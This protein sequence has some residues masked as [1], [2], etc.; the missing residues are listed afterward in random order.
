VAITNPRDIP[1]LLLWLSADSLSL[2]AGAN[3]NTWNDL[4]GANNHCTF[5]NISDSGL[6]KY[7]P[8]GGPA[9]GPQVVL[10]G[11]GVSE[12]MNLPAAIFSGVTAAEAFVGIKS[13]NQNA[14]LWSVS[15]GGGLAS[16]YPH[17]SGYYENFGL[18]G[19]RPQITST[20]AWATS[21]QQINTRA[22]AGNFV[23]SAASG[24]FTTYS[25]SGKTIG[26]DVTPRML[27][28]NI[29]GMSGGISVVLLWNK[30]LNTTERADVNTWL[31]ANPSG[32][33]PGTPPNVPTGLN[34]TAITKSG[35][36][37]DWTAPASGPTPTG[38]DVR[39]NGAAEGT[40]GWADIGVATEHEL[41][42]L[43]ANT[44]Y[45][46]EV[47]SVGA[48][49]NS[50]WVS[51]LFTT[52]GA[53]FVKWWDGDSMEPAQLLGWWNGTAIQP[54]EVLGWWD[55]DSIEPIEWVATLGGYPAEV[56]AD[57]PLAYYRL[58]EASGTAMLDSSGSGRHGTYTAVTLG[59]AGLLG[60]DADKAAT[61]NG[62]TSEGIVPYAAWMSPSAVT[63]EAII[64]PGVDTGTHLI[65]GRTNLGSLS[66]ANYQVYLYQDATRLCAHVR[67]GGVASDLQGAL[68][69]VQVGVR[70]HVA[71]TYNG[72]NAV[73]YINGVATSTITKTG[74]LAS[75][76]TLP[77]VV[78]ASSWN[79]LRYPG[80]LDE[81]AFYGTGLSAARIAAHYAARGVLTYAAVVLAD[82]PSAYY[83]LGDPEPTFTHYGYA[84][85]SR[86]SISE[87]SQYA[88]VDVSPTTYWTT[89]GVPTGWLLIQFTA[90][91][92]IT[93]YSIQRRD[94]L[95]N[96]NPKD[97][98]MEGSD[99]GTTWTVIDTRT[100]I[101][102]PT[103]GEIKSFT[104]TAVSPGYTYYRLN[105]TANNGDTY[106][107]VASLLMGDIL[108]RD[109][110]G[111]GRHGTYNL[112]TRGAAG[113]LTGD[114]DTAATFNGTTSYGHVV[115]YAAWMDPANF[116][117]EARIKTSGTG[118]RAI[119]D[120]DGTTRSWQLR[121]NGGN[122]EFVKIAGGIV[123]IT[124]TAT[125][126]NGAW[127]H[128]AVT[129]DGTNLV[130]YIDG[131][132]V[133]TTAMSSPAGAATPIRIGC[134]W[135]GSPAAVWNG[136]IDEAA[137][138][139]T[140]LSAAQIAA[141]VAAL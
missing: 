6:F 28:S 125:L 128:V 84:H 43:A 25:A 53:P 7:Q 46:V 44:S 23:V 35:G 33:L 27:A 122:L 102:W 126:N 93:V 136:Q 134:N 127:H 110:S 96:R 97:W 8:T 79:G 137:F 4:S 55:G 139:S 61:F 52:W 36:H 138:Y 108:M 49:G 72:A 83:R 16:H 103:A 50:A 39:L 59:T 118:V 106:L 98:T 11:G 32:G 124:H 37:L 81:V 117:L 24:A 99:N 77:F 129:Y 141:H 15:S 34:V 67:A 119:L 45:Q 133:K 22:G 76:S 13:T 120:R 54:A 89:A 12:R 41:V 62:T 109:S 95:P 60:G 66:D 58:G 140:A 113:G 86:A 68:G 9:G 121:L 92:V 71:I 1:G 57:A 80:V 29:Y 42:G 56:L 87:D 123:T 64:R 91:T 101:T 14:P 104:T 115:P 114:T 20:T 5:G 69:S 10:T 70:T 105:V 17:S 74:A 90:Q 107:S 40:A 47:R 21:W 85:S 111:N 94:D 73:L 130:F 31:A 82:T 75:G 63:L 3:V 116:T 78:G 38:Y 88:F 65:T 135:V 48:E 100:G 19:E 132:P 2:A 26:F 18:T 112:V 30:V 131:A 51:V